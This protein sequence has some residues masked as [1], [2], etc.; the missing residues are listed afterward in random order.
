MSNIIK[1]YKSFETQ[2]SY[3]TFVKAALRGLLSRNEE[4]RDIKFDIILH[5]YCLEYEDSPTLCIY[6]DSSLLL[7]VKTDLGIDGKDEVYRIIFQYN[8]F[9]KKEIISDLSYAEVLKTLEEKLL[10]VSLG[11]NSFYEKIVAK[12]ILKIITDHCRVN[13]YE[14]YIIGNK[15]FVDKIEFLRIL[16]IS[17]EEIVIR[18]NNSNYTHSLKSD[19]TDEDKYAKILEY[20]ERLEHIFIDRYTHLI[21]FLDISRQI[22]NLEVQQIL[23]NYDVPTQI[24]G[25]LNNQKVM[26]YT[27]STIC[28][29][30]V[31]LDPINMDYDKLFFCLNCLKAISNS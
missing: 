19:G 20:L 21:S 6:Y 29:M 12:E 23:S 13:P 16:H 11:I 1:N 5:E 7:K 3:L 25:L 26:K 9:T 15:I 27:D 8:P 24:Y 28:I 14:T 4:L 22:P 17:N 2:K 31:H 10:P 30:G 18:I